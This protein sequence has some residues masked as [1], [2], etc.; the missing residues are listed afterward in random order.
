MVPLRIE[1]ETGSIKVTF[2]DDLAEELI[3]MK[4]D[5]INRTY[6]EGYGI[7]DIL[8]DLNGQT[9]EIVANVSFDEYSEENRLNPKRILAKYI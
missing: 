2:F 4:K 3:S 5:E 8:E 1:D 7:E 6:D 9:I